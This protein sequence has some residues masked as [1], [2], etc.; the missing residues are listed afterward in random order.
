MSYLLY[1][2]DASETTKPTYAVGH[3]DAVD[4][5]ILRDL[6]QWGWRVEE[7]TNNDPAWL[8]ARQDYHK[9]ME[10]DGEGGEKKSSLWDY[11]R[12][13]NAWRAALESGKSRERKRLT[14][15][16]QPR[17]ASSHR[18]SFTRL[19]TRKE[20]QKLPG[21][22][23]VP[24]AGERQ[25]EETYL[26]SGA[27]QERKTIAEIRQQAAQKK[28]ASEDRN[29]LDPAKSLGRL[30]PKGPSICHYAS[31]NE[32]STAANAQLEREL[33]HEIKE[34]VGIEGILKTTQVSVISEEGICVDEKGEQVYFPPKWNLPLF[35][36]EEVSRSSSTKSKDS[37]AK[38]SLEYVTADIA[39]VFEVTDRYQEKDEPDQEAYGL[40]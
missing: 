15:S 13:E 6:R 17:T 12:N 29:R 23:R 11:W 35:P 33:L 20:A 1:P 38:G 19:V 32:A 39:A 26:M 2:L 10:A 37:S 31:G 14:K 27:N 4:E 8:A 24:Q 16:P 30:D 18:S 21:A 36:W 22:Q 9:R 40:N 3:P 25:E 28:E 5:V 7:T 34:W